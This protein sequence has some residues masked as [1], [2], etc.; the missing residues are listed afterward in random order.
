MFH[1]FSFFFFFFS[2]FSLSFCLD[3]S[4]LLPLNC[5]QL[6]FLTSSNGGI[7]LDREFPFSGPPPSSIPLVFLPYFTRCSR[8]ST[9]EFYIDEC[10][11]GSKLHYHYTIDDI[12]RFISSAKLNFASIHRAPMK[13]RPIYELL[14]LLDSSV[15]PLSGQRALVIGS[16]D[17]IWEAALIAKNIG[18]VVTSDYNRLTYDHP[19]LSTIGPEQLNFIEDSFDLILAINSI[20]HSGLGRY[21]DALAPDGDLRALKQLRSHLKE[22]GKLILTVAVGPDLLSWNLGR[23]YGRE[24]F[25]LLMNGWTIEHSSGWKESMLDYQH[26]YRRRI[27]SSFILKPTT[28][29]NLHHSQ[30]YDL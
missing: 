10:D 18:M 7:L 20:D 15:H 19:L 8:I 3:L 29:V 9:A 4:T 1:F 22:N 23:R 21:C 5:S 12:N 28:M 11:G 2:S 13:H 25:P 26:D 24:R 14:S 16:I 6:D 30:H 27:E 17:P